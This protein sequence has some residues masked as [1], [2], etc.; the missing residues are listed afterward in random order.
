[1]RIEHGCRV[2]HSYAISLRLGETFMGLHDASGSGDGNCLQKLPG[3]GMYIVV[4]KSA[5]RELGSHGSS[6][7]I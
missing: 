7:I 5:P 4:E 3:Y 6:F 2:N 1:M